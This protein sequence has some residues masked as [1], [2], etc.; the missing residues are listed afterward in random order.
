MGRGNAAIWNL[1]IAWETY[2]DD[3]E[4]FQKL[5]SKWDIRAKGYTIQVRLSWDVLWTPFILSSMSFGVVVKGDTE[6]SDK[7]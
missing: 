5:V 4:P 1:P 7:I 3:L 2:S 6:L